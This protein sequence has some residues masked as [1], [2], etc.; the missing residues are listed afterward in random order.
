MKHV[1]DITVKMK[2][3]KELVVFMEETGNQKSNREEEWDDEWTRK[4]NRKLKDGEI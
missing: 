1:T 3:E 4:L 2:I